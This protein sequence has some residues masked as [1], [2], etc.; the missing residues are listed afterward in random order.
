MFEWL[1]SWFY[2]LAE[3]PELEV[4]KAVEPVLN[5]SEPVY[6]LCECI[7][8]FPKMFKLK[9]S[10][11][12]PTFVGDTYIEFA[13]LTCKISGKTFEWKETTHYFSRDIEVTFKCDLLTKDEVDLINKTYQTARLARIEQVSIWKDKRK[14][15]KRE[16][17]T[18][19]YVKALQNNAHSLK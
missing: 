13:K 18:A 19:I 17:L 8:K 9:V 2:P 15:A 6:S 11:K 12:L 16:E 3:V 1:K 5:I 10:F 4:S 14:Q 7:T